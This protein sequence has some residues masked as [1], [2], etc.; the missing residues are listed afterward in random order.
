VLFP[1]AL[2][3]GRRWRALLAAAVS[4]LVFTALGLAA[5]GPA[6][7]LAF[8][9]DLPQLRVIV[10]GGGLPW[11][12]MPSPYVLLLSLRAAPDAAMLAQAL[13]ALGAALCVWRAWRD[14]HA[15]FEAKA[16]VL[17]AGAM[18]V[19][20]YLFGYDLTWAAVA[21]AFLAILGLRDG[22]CRGEREILLAAWLAPVVLMP[23]FFLCRAQF[24][25]L[26]LIL[27]LAAAMRRTAR[28][29]SPSPT[30]L[31][32]GAPPAPDRP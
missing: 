16:A 9:H 12:Q 2:I 21:V 15:P 27:L 29:P 22:F 10:D 26:A 14:P 25:C 28:V 20:P 13:A 24:G 7:F 1:V 31:S 30:P 18:L 17:F 19:S 6:A 5:F 23:A 3:A 32:P 4:G 11:G 8:L